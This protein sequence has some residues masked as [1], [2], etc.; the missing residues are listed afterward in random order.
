MKK[1]A[2]YVEGDQRDEEKE[3][4]GGKWGCRRGTCWSGS[5]CLLSES[6]PR[7]HHAYPVFPQNNTLFLN[8]SLLYAS[9]S[10]TAIYVYSSLSTQKKTV[11][12]SQLQPPSRNA[13]AI[14]QLLRVQSVV[15]S[16]ALTSKGLSQTRS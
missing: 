13:F 7:E 12:C 15:Q 11:S 10:L 3:N 2:N 1:K 5:V 16:A 4:Q 6:N 9:T 14:T 8:L